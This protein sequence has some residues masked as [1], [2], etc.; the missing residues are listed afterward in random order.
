METLYD[1]KD[2][3]QWELLYIACGNAKWF[4]HSGSQFGN[5]FRKLNLLLPYD[6]AIVLGI[7]PK[8]FKSYIHRKTCTQ[9]FI[10]ALFIIAKT[11]KQL[12]CPLVGMNIQTME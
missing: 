8:D 6:L 5:S 10:A 7:Y 2:V 3:R 4:R 9:M 11:W 12:R 1:G